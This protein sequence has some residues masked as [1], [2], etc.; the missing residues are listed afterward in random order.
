MNKLYRK[1]DIRYEKKRVREMV[2]STDSKS[3]NLIRLKDGRKTYA[4]VDLSS[5][6]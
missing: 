2:E 3:I 6:N 5:R 4:L 1:V